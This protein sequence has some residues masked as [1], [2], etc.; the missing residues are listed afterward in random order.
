MKYPRRTITR[1][2]SIGPL[3]LA[4]VGMLAVLVALRQ[5][6]SRSLPPPPDSPASGDTLNVAIEVSPV[7]ISLGGDTLSG[8]YYNLIRRLCAAHG[9]PVRFTP[10][11]RLDDA[12]RGLERGRYQLVASDIPVTTELRERFLFLDPVATE[13]QVLVQAADSAT[14]RPVVTSQFDLAGRT[15]TLPTGS[16]FISRL[17]ALSREIGDT[18]LVAEDPDYSSEQLVILTATGEVPL[19]VVSE[20]VAR[21]LLRHYPNLDASVLISLR[22]FHAWA[23]APADSALRD[24]LSNWL[25]TL[26]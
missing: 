8:T 7:G 13:R 1:W 17:G 14:G 20:G 9:R 5:C 22:Q 4:V 24:T 21:P 16:P 26:K 11:T 19:T 2:S 3:L 18:I 6:S 15:V 12:L 10:F 25:R 23:V